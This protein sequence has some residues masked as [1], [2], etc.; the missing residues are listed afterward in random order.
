ML[1]SLVAEEKRRLA[2][3]DTVDVVTRRTSLREYLDL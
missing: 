1:T 2:V 3:E